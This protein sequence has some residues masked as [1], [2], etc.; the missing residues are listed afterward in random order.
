MRGGRWRF[1]ELR[2]DGDRDEGRRRVPA[3]LRERRRDGDAVCLL[4]LLPRSDVL[5]RGDF[6]RCDK[7]PV[8][9]ERLLLLLLWRDRPPA[10]DEEPF[11]GELTELLWPRR[12]DDE[13]ATVSLRRR[14]SGERLCRGAPLLSYR[15]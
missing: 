4:L 11:F 13:A 1:L 3:G 5:R 7:S 9:R 6:E 8:R 2:L 15:V 14:R 10:A 12:D